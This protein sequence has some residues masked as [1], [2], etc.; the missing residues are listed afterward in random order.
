MCGL[1]LKDCRQWRS[2]CVCTGF[3]LTD[4]RGSH[5]PAVSLPT[6]TLVYFFFYV[7][8]YEQIISLPALLWSRYLSWVQVEVWMTTCHPTLTTN[9]PIVSLCLHVLCPLPS[10]Y[11]W[12]RGLCPLN[13]CRHNKPPAAEFFMSVASPNEHMWS[14]PESM[15]QARLKVERT[16]PA[17]RPVCRSSWPRRF[18]A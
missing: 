9:F 6:I 17:C 7:C 13:K 3:S 4:A 16:V 2:V 12:N 18:R 8:F 11:F 14:I 1:R 10:R 5:E 15:M